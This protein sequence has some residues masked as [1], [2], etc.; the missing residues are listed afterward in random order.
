[1]SYKNVEKTEYLVVLKTWWGN[2]RPNIVSACSARDAAI[3][4]VKQVKYFK[5]IEVYENASREFVSVFS[6]SDFTDE[7]SNSV[8]CHDASPVDT[9]TSTALSGMP[10]AILVSLS[11]ILILSSISI[12]AAVDQYF[13]IKELSRTSA[14]TLPSLTSFIFSVF[15]KSLSAIGGILS[16][17]WIERFV[18]FRKPCGWILASMLTIVNL[19]LSALILNIV[20]GANVMGALGGA[21]VI[22]TFLILRR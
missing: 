9:N 10:W 6:E 21:T 12:Y 15:L 7:I 5:S 13:L 20:Y 16:L 1:M 4:M 22:S 2:S 18:I 17:G 3:S 11:T 14:Q 19:G 8:P